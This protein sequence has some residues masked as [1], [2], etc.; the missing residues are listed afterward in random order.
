M[1]RKRLQHTVYGV[2]SWARGA[3]ELAALQQLRL[4]AHIRWQQGRCIT[5]VPIG[6]AYSRNPAIYYKCLHHTKAEIKAGR[7]PGGQEDGARA[8]GAAS[9][10]Q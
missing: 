5:A 6:V 7:M 4:A 3:A 8:S 10:I 2:A 9:V 1:R